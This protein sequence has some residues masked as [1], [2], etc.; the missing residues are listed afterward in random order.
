MNKRKI[1]ILFIVGVFIISGSVAL[2]F[3]NKIYAS[4]TIEDTIIYIRTNSNF[5]EVTD[6]ISP[7]LNNTNSFVW[8]AKKKNYP[9]VIKAGR[10]ELK[11]GMNNNDLVNLL[12][13]GNQKAIT[14]SFNNQDSLE[15]LAGRIA[16]QIEPDSLTILNTISDTDFLHKNDFKAETALGMYIPNSYQVYWNTSAENFRI[17]MLMEY[18]RFWSTERIKKA[19]KQQ[20]T[21][22]QVVALASIVQ[23][24]T[25]TIQERPIVAQLYL[26]RLHNNWPLQADPT[27]IYV[28][29][30]QQ[31]QDVV[32]K[33]V[34]FK[35]LEI[36]SKYNTYLNIGLPPGPIGMPDISAINAVLNPKKHN[37]YYM[38]V[39]VENFGQH[40]F[41]ETLAQHNRNATKYQRWLTNQGVNR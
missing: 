1:L 14:I 4:N 38:C 27:I 21:P 37:Y 12:R 20:L 13:S 5:E 8:V 23:K 30:E 32:I 31:G 18:H 41:A 19:K 22:Q 15:K 2:H 25:Q 28:I 17:K 7:F 39:D 34:L 16:Q 35:D 11:K 6:T 24:E 33:R 10:Y 26:N 36:K 29:K 40:L 9:N 3:Y